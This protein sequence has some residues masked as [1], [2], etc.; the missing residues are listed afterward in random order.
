M[1]DITLSQYALPPILMVIMGIIYKFTPEISDRFK[2]L[3]VIAIG[4]GLSWLAML[5][6][7]EPLTIKMVIDYG[8]Y[9]LMSVGAASIGLYK[10][11]QKSVSKE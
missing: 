11:I 1:E 3:I 2:T 4:I 9:G 7:G 8:L 6:K 5:Y 10:V